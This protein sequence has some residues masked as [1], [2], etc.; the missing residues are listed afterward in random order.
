MERSID[1][2]DRSAAPPS[3]RRMSVTV[4]TETQLKN[5]I[6]NDATIELGGNIV[7]TPVGGENS[8]ITISGVTGL[9]IN[10]NGYTIGFASSDEGNGK[11][12]R[13][14]SNSEVTMNDLTI[15]NGYPNVSN[16][17]ARI[18]I[19]LRLPSLL[20]HTLLHLFYTFAAADNNDDGLVDYECNGVG[21][22]FCG[23][24]YNRCNTWS[25]VWRWHLCVWFNDHHDELRDIRKYGWLGTF[26]HILRSK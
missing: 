13:I 15:S 3:H 5:A 14:E 2:A 25:S 12:F 19:C 22:F 26:H 23:S 4:T 7:L 17:Y 9:V 11:C 8:A 21:I 1:N 20:S 18:Q 10:G 6:A 24:I 16:D